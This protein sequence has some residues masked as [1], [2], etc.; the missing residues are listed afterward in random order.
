MLG[1]PKRMQATARMA[2]VMSSALPARR[3]LIRNVSHKMKALCC[4]TLFLAGCGLVPQKISVTD[5]EVQS[6]FS[7][8]RFFPREDY[9]FSPL[10]TDEKTD[11]RIEKH[12]KGAYDVMLHIYGGTSR[13]IAFRRNETG[14]RWIHEQEVFQ[15]PKTY[16][17]PDGRLREQIVLTYETEPLSGATKDTLR[18]SYFGEDK[19][20]SGRSNISLPEA[21]QILSEWGYR[22]EG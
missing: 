2:S 18:I 4:L 19:R 6:L 21:E 1:T 15:G 8:A 20:L 7:Q 14:Y 3:R 22:N 16:D 13:T 10:P 9:G 12:S 5:P 11:I 17:S